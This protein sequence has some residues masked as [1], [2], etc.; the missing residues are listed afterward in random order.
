[1]SELPKGWIE[2]QLISISNF[3]DYRG[4]TPIKT[5]SGIPLITAKNVKKGYISRE[6]REFI[7]FRGMGIIV[8][9]V[10]VILGVV[11]H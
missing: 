3:I 1:M 4:K 9:M 10:L 7:L 6:P 2:C 8:Q 11:L 5:T